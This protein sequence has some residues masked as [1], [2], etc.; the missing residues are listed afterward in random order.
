MVSYGLSGQTA[1]LGPGSGAGKVAGAGD[2]ASW[3]REKGVAGPSGEA[4]E[5][6]RSE[7]GAEEEGK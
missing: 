6:R 7:A 1:S 5:S 2:L 3:L 4:F